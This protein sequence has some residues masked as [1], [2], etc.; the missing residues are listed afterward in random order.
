MLKLKNK[1]GFAS[2]VEVI[3]TSIIFIIASV[4]IFAT[5]ST[6]GTEGARSQQKLEALYAGK[7]VL[8]ELRSSMN[9]TVW[10]SGD[11]ATGNTHRKNVYLGGGQFY[12]VN[13]ITQDIPGLN[14]REVTLNVNY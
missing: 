6:L 9:T 2:I 4:G 3:I 8:D 11:L 13:W 12:D 14:V 10:T 7:S 1:K 5:L